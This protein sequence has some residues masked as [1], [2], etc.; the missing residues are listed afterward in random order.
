MKQ[1]IL[2]ILIITSMNLYAQCQG[3][4]NNDGLKNVVDIVALVNQVLL[5]DTECVEQSVHGCL[6]SQACNYDASA[7]IDNNSCYYCYEDDC[8]TYS[9]DAYDCNG[10]CIADLDCFGECGGEA[11]EDEC[12]ECGGNNMNECG[13]CNDWVSLWGECYNIESTTTLGLFDS[14]LTG[15]IPSEIGRLIN[16]TDIYLHSNELT[17]SIPSEIGQLTNLRY[18]WLSDNQLSGEIPSE[19]GQLTNLNSIWLHNNELS[20]HI[21][22]S[23]CNLNVNFSDFGNGGVFQIGNNS[24]CPPYPQC[25]ENYV[26]TQDTSNCP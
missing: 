13:S 18:L 23:I 1:F 16:L 2:S 21:S 8:D 17:G 26:E 5:G 7:L 4:L 15:E 10:E 19:I 24:F 25:I 20:G 12:G 22:E 14:N 9:E 3:D 11:I 6:D